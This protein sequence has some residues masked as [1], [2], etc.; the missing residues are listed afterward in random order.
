MERL[1]LR[2]CQILTLIAM[3]A[4]AQTQNTLTDA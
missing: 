1:M 2:L 4:D 3:Q